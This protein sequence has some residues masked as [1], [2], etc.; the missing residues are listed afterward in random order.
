MGKTK[1][2]VVK[3]EM[4]EREADDI[5]IKT[6]SGVYLGAG[7]L[8]L[9]CLDSPPHGELMNPVAVIVFHVFPSNCCV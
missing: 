7:F 4:F 8:R 5:A 3:I 2:R 9:P 1:L 6:W